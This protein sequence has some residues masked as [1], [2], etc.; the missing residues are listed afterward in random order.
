M[1]ANEP[2]TRG[3]Y[4]T[5]FM[6]QGKG[7]TGREPLQNNVNK[8]HEELH[9]KSVADAI[10]PKRPESFNKYARQVGRL[11]G[12]GSDSPVVAH[13]L[14]AENYSEG[15]PKDEGFIGVRRSA[16]EM[17]LEG[18]GIDGS[19]VKAGMN[20]GSKKKGG[21]SR[22]FPTE[23]T[24]SISSYDR[25]GDVSPVQAK[26]PKSKHKPDVW[27]KKGAQPLTITESLY[28]SDRME[29]GQIPH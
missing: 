19:P 12:I 3:S 21:I 13:A 26:G 11:Y 4:G 28:L 10:Q 25:F 17:V 23:E 16:L 5:I 14:I 1:S 24:K 18:E 9:H 2:V 6:G 15:N 8:L 29:G 7:H 27:N 22:E 20:D